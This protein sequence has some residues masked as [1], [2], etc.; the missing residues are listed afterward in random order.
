M[1]K[2]K[3]RETAGD[4]EIYIKTTVRNLLIY[5]GYIVV[6]SVVNYGM[7]SLMKFYFA[8]GMTK[9]FL[10][11]NINEN[12]QSATF[13]TGFITNTDVWQFLNNTLPDGLYFE[14]WYDGN[15]TADE[16]LGYILYQNKILGKVRMTQKRVKSEA[17]TIPKMVSNII[18]NCYPSYSSAVESTEAYGGVSSVDPSYPA[19]SFRTDSSG[20]GLIHGR[21]SSYS[22]NGFMIDLPDK[23]SGTH[24]LITS[25]FNNKWID[26][27]TRALFIEFTVYN[28]NINYFTQIQLVIEFPST[29]GM[30]NSWSIRTSKLFRYSSNFDYFVLACEVLFI[31]YTIYFTLEEIFDASCSNLNLIISLAFPYNL[32]REYALIGRE[33]GRGIRKRLRYLCLLKIETKKEDSY[34]IYF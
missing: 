13:R 10:D 15:S 4:N 30:I 23:S 17:C 5:I 8:D 22:P 26:L 33:I 27:N 16:N 19:W 7:L 34:F 25:L 21:I 24:S 9:L 14:T 3:K 20:S 29:G 11:T 12:G 18:R 32:R 31:L 1:I 2:E 28:G 6:I